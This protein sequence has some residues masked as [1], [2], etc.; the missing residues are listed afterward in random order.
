M[1]LD[2]LEQ[3]QTA[4]LQSQ[5]PQLNQPNHAT[6]DMLALFFSPQTVTGVRC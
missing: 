4:L 3:S 6:T 1:V 5:G 2:V